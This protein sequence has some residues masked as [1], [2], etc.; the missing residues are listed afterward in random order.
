MSK[1]WKEIKMLSAIE[2]AK[3]K[4]EQAYHT[5]PGQRAWLESSPLDSYE[6]E[7][8]RVKLFVLEGSPCK[9]YVLADYGRMIVKP[10]ALAKRLR[11]INARDEWI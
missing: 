6:D 8:Y 2:K 4:V 7:S 5:E 3:R 9:G 10:M 1:G 11:E